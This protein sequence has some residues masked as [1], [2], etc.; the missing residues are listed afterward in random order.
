MP[1][2]KRQRSTKIRVSYKN[3]LNHPDPSYFFQ[4]FQSLATG[5]QFWGGGR[6]LYQRQYSTS[7]Y[8]INLYFKAEAG[9]VW[10]VQPSERFAQFE[11][12]Q[13]F[14]NICISSNCARLNFIFHSRTIYNI[15]SS[16]ILETIRSILLLP[17]HTCGFIRI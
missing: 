6:R 8:C 10:L 17:L 15:N 14:N 1:L 2:V 13:L 11:L 3:R 9:G 5:Q 4:W 12:M 7:T 16:N